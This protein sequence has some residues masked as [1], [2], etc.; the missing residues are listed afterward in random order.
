MSTGFDLYNYIISI[1]TV[2]YTIKKRTCGLIVIF[3]VDIGTT[4]SSSC[5]SYIKDEKSIVHVIKW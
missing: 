5:F 2:H 3:W 1:G 4:F